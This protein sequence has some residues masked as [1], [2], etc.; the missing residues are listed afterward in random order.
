MNAPEYRP[1]LVEKPIE[2]HGYDIDVLG[3]VS[4]LVYIR[5][6]EDLRGHLLD[7]YYPIQDL[8]KENLSPVLA[9]THAEYKYPLTIFDKV[10]GRVWISNLT[11]SRWTCSFEIA[12]P[13]RI[14]CLGQQSGYFFNVERKRPAA[15]PEKLQELYARETADL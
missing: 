8:L 7:V 2:I 1:L 13:E 9:E 5:W 6:F 14:H 4:N 15:V 3:I 11:R 10:V 12:S